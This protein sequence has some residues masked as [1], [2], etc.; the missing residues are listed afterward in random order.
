MKSS[1]QWCAAGFAVLT[2]LC[3]GMSLSAQETGDSAGAADY[4]IEY[5]ASPSQVIVE[6][7]VEN[8]RE[9]DDTAPLLRIYGDGRVLVHRNQYAVDGGDYEMYLSQGELTT[10]LQTLYDNG[11]LT[12]DADGV[13]KQRRAAKT[14]EVNRARSGQGALNAVSD[15]EISVV[16]VNLSAFQAS[17]ARQ[18]VEDYNKEVRAVDLQREAAAYPEIQELSGVASVESRLRELVVHS[19]LQKVAN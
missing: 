18:A 9:S 19:G 15:V 1:R 8:M 6:Y 11:V 3:V 16:R 13:A 2:A 7:D 10:L 17:G 5:S 12:Y 4:F 14:E